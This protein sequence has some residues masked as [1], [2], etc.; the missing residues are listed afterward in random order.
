MV[1]RLR[2]R[3]RAFTHEL[4]RCDGPAGTITRRRNRHLSFGMGTYYC[5][6]AALARM[7]T[8]ECLRI[9]LERC[10]G[11]RPAYESPDRLPSLPSGHRLA[12]LRVAF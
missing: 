10:P 12:S 2:P 3:V 9:L 6:G 4:L 11:L 5:L 7:E 1:D 8:D